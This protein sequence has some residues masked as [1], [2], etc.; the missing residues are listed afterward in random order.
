MT[1]I[2]FLAFLNGKVVKTPIEVKNLS[3]RQAG[4][5]HRDRFDW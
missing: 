2:L 1:D 3:F 5:I 4:K